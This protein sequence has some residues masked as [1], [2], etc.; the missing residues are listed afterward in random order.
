M[1]GLWSIGTMLSGVVALLLRSAA[2]L[3]GGHLPGWATW[4]FL[5]L[6]AGL[7]GPLLS[8]SCIRP[9]PTV[10]LHLGQRERHGRI[11]ARW[12]Y[13]VGGGS[14]K[15]VAGNGQCFSV[16]LCPLIQR[17]LWLRAPR[18]DGHLIKAAF[19]EE[20]LDLELV[21]DAALMRSIQSSSCTMN[22]DRPTHA[23]ARP[24]GAFPRA[25]GRCASGLGT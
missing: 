10:S 12:R 15:K 21:R 11:L 17:A 6:T 8:Q 19:R 7:S 2:S 5:V 18:P 25:R 24:A 22:G 3:S 23:L 14:R 20:R 4:P 1:T 9:S 13:G 16:F